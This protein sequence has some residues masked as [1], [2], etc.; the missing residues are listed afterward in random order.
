MSF[1]IPDNNRE[2][3]LKGGPNSPL[4]RTSS[5]LPSEWNGENCYRKLLSSKR[6]LLFKMRNLESRLGRVTFDKIWNLTT[7]FRKVKILF[8]DFKTRANS[9]ISDSKTKAE[10]LKEV[11]SRFECCHKL[12]EDVMCD[13]LGGDTDVGKSDIELCAE[14]STSQSQ[15]NK[16]SSKLSTVS[17]NYLQRKIELERQRAEINALVSV[18]WLR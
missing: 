11:D 16:C 2:M 7:Q 10:L 4:S 14:D 1:K 12:Y 17:V 3:Q 15:L 18:I 6:Q 9:N 5:P 8:S 13:G